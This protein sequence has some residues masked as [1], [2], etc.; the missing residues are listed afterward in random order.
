M[1]RRG[2]RLFKVAFIQ[3][4]LKVGKLALANFK[5]FQVTRQTGV[6]SQHTVICNTGRLSAVAFT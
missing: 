6:K 2:H 1:K 5:K 4:T 3:Q